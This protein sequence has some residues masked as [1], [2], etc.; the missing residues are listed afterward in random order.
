M[1]HLMMKD[2]KELKQAKPVQVHADAIV[3][4]NKVIRKLKKKYE[5]DPKD[6]QTIFD[7]SYLDKNVPGHMSMTFLVAVDWTDARDGTQFYVKE[8]V[9][10]TMEDYRD[11]SN[12][13]MLLQY[14][15]E[16][17]LPF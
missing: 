2:F 14:A 5:L 4:C 17:E 7:S 13:L 12:A 6:K 16:N 9:Y 3:Q 10:F 8:T 15:Y 1:K 11:F